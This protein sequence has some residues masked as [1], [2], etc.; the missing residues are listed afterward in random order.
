[1]VVPQ[2]RMSVT[3][4]QE[5]QR[6]TAGNNACLDYVLSNVVS[7][8]MLPTRTDGNIITTEREL[9]RQ[10]YRSFVHY[11]LSGGTGFPDLTP[12]DEAEIE[13]VQARLES[14]DSLEGR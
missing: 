4:N 10:R 7:F 12:D 14:H 3:E 8:D 13:A 11:I 1:M 5:V 9:L 2:F 6:Q